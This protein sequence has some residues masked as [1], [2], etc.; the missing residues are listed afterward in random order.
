MQEKN[1]ESNIVKYNL[2]KI[3]TKRVFLPLI[4]I[5]VVAVGQ[6][7]LIQ[8]GIIM[9]VTALVQIAF[10]IP[11][12][13]IADKWGHKNALVLGSALTT[14][15]V[16][17]YI[18]FPGFAGALI[19]SVIFFLG[20]SFT[21]GTVQAFIHETLLALGREDKY[22]QIMGKAQ[23]YGLLGNIVLV[24]L[25][26]LTYQ[27]NNKLPFIIGFICLF[28]SCLIASSF[29]NPP[30]RESVR[31]EGRTFFK[32]FREILQQTSW[33]KILIVFL[34]FGIISSG[35]DQVSIYREI[36]FKTINIPIQYFGFLLG[37]GSLLA[38]IGGRYIYK[39]KGLK[40]NLFYLLDISYLSIAYIM[41]GLSHSVLLIVIG[42]IMIPAFDRTRGIIYES[43]L[44][45][46]F[47]QIKYKSTLISSMNFFALGNGLWL[48]LILGS[49]VVHTNVI[50]AHAYFGIFLFVIVAP[51]LIGHTL[52]YKKLQT[53]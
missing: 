41:I 13:L 50:Q 31:K 35:F 8:L 36:V 53:I 44:F 4:A 23:S 7:S 37:I 2:Y 26:P 17:P 46:E 38:A 42:F 10:E 22:A 11:T 12:G 52:G 45:E 47:P 9:S 6:V 40:T 29:T 21:S 24:S 15:S 49:L 25:V 43:K 27:I 34:I 18:F 5:Y 48:P 39:L 16:L 32:E 20:G 3:F 19:A 1:L 51:L 14:I 33:H 28:I 30:Q